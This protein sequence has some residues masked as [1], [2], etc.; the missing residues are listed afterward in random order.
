ML[1][2]IDSSSQQ[3][4][5]AM[6]AH[7][8]APAWRI[9]GTGAWW[10][11]VR[12]AA[13]SRTRLSDFTF[14]FHF[15]A[16]EKAMAAHSS[17]P[18]WRIPGT[19]AWRAAAHGAAQSR[20]RLSDL[21]AAAANTGERQRFGSRSLLHSFL[22]LLKPH[23]R[24]FMTTSQADQGAF[25]KGALSQANCLTHYFLIKYILIHGDTNVSW[26]VHYPLR[27]C[28]YQKPNLGWPSVPW[29]KSA[30]G[31]ETLKTWH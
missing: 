26:Q 23:L 31:L 14:T 16:L 29:E 10:A 3:M 1:H 2:L 6:A 13:Q 25:S 22:H 5:K 8:S 30:I 12:G 17:A 27:Q 28:L 11:A 19:G 18:A 20:T 9:P 7:S 4:E 21:A 24:H 15:P